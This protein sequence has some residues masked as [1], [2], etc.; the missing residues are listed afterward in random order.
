MSN[1]GRKRALPP[2]ED[3]FLVLVHLH[4]GLFE[5]DIAYWFGVSQSTVSRIILTW[6]NLLYLQSKQIP[7]WPPK[8]L[9]LSNIPK[10][11]KK[12]VHLLA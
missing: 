1:K 8:P 4:L 11:F 2:L 9:V 12:N 10:A 7:I 3:F 6:M 5:C